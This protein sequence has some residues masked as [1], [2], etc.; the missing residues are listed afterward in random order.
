MS[1]LD[2]KDELQSLD[3]EAQLEPRG[4][5]FERQANYET[6]STYTGR[7]SAVFDAF[8]P[9]YDSTSV[10]EDDSPYPEVRSAVANFDDPD[11]PASTIRAWVLGIA[12]SVIIPGMNQFFYLRYPTLTVAGLVA[13]LLAFPVGRLWH[14]ICP[15]WTIL[16]LELN[17]GPFSIKEHVLVTI[18]A[19]V[20]APNAYSND[21]IA[22]S[23]VFYRVNF[24]MGYAWLLVISTQMIGFSVGGIARRFL[25]APPSMIWPNTLVSCALF[26]TL[27][28]QLYAGIGPRDGITR[29]RFFLYAFCGATLWYFVPGYLFQALSYF[30]WVCWIW[31]DNVKVNQLF[32]YRSGLGMSILT[33]DWNQVTSY[34]G[35]PLSTPWWAEANI[36]IGFVFFF[37][38][39]TPI[40][41][42]TNVWDSQYL[43][44]SDVKAYNN[45]GG[46]YEVDKIVHLS[47]ATL[48]VGAYE[49]YSPLFLPVTFALSY[50]M[51]FMAITGPSLYFQIPPFI[52]LTN[53]GVH[54]LMLSYYPIATVTHA[55]IY[56]WKPIKLQFRRSLQEQPDIHARLMSQYPQ[57]PEWYY[58]CIFGITFTFA[59]VAIGHWPTGMPIWTLVIALVL[60][61]IYVIPVG[62]IQALT[63]KQV[64]LN[65]ISELIIGFMIPGRPIPMML[66][67]TFGYTTVTQAIQFTGDF[68]LGH[69]MKIPPRPMFWAQVIASII[70]ATVQLG[71]QEWMFST[72]PHMCLRDQKDSFTCNATQVFGT[73][74]VLW[75][76]IGPGRQ[77]TQGQ[78]YY[79]LCLSFFFII[80]AATP[81]I[82]WL[83]TRR[84]PNTI[85]NYLHFPLIFSGLG[86]IPP[87]TAVNFVPWAIIGFIFQYIIRRKHFAW[88]AKYNYVLSAALDGGTAIGVI[89]VYTCLQFPRNG[90]IG[91]GTIQEWWGNTVHKNT[92]DWNFT[93]LKHVSDGETFGPHPGEW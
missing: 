32:G 51:S 83:I 39:I 40:L 7:D 46:Q 41:Y 52:N 22:V 90:E 37:W 72:I 21:I 26:N 89:L 27:H 54:Q 4:K 8:D 87:A 78:L 64:P 25:V 57:V 84:W 69:Y 47:N 49:S 75:G 9:N 60:A 33:F 28:S 93:A 24:G 31:P 85:L 55:L 48:N 30:T 71:V 34:S 43:P 77:F 2:S 44:I 66:F 61:L 91:R 67:K 62:M 11:M 74:S 68:K 73:A 58:L 81:V 1:R 38:F 59:C 56:F 15:A 42:Y 50:G 16:G 92:A 63:N 18:M 86:W 65:V 20:G 80:G 70:A 82:L 76:A 14:R 6:S 17:P 35:S 53:D 19:S 79:G 36:F 88:W 23:W 5:S 12:F 45:T 10:L 3:Y 29:E 13:Q